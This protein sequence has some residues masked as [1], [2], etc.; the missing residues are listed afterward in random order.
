M[1]DLDLTA[2]GTDGEA[3]TA[4]SD[5]E[6]HSGSDSSS[7]QP[8]TRPGTQ[9]TTVKAIVMDGQ[10]WEL[11]HILQSVLEPLGVAIQKM[12]AGTWVQE[13][14]AVRGVAEMFS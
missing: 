4:S 7:C 12:E 9:P 2:S 6:S 10:F 1:A 13:M 14:L 11:L 8:S 5:S 3:S